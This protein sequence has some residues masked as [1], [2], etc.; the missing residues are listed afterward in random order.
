MLPVSHMRVI[1]PVVGKVPGFFHLVVHPR[2]LGVSRR[3]LKLFLDFLSSLASVNALKQVIQLLL[4]LFCRQQAV[5][6]L[7][8][9][10]LLLVVNYKLLILLVAQRRAQVLFIMQALLFDQLLDFHFHF[11]GS[12][13]C[14]LA[15]LL[16][17]GAPSHFS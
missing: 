14:L 2:E 16:S 11:I 12:G 9:F 17:R 7:N 4:E 6:E 15:P 5:L 8:L 3:T 13:I 1:D 10:L